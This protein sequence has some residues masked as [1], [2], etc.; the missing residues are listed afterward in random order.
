MKMIMMMM[1]MMTMMMTRMV[2]KYYLVILAARV[3]VP[4]GH[5]RI[6]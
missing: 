2:T 6:K 3:C 5:L 4:A 1:M